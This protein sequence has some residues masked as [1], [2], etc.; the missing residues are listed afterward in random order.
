MEIEICKCTDLPQIYFDVQGVKKPIED[1]SP[2]QRCTALLPIILLETDTPLIIDQPEDNLDNQFI[3]DLVVNTLRSLKECRQII[4]AT[5]NPNIPVSGD[6][7]NIL[8][9]RPDG[10][11][12]KVERNGSIDY[13]PII[14]DVKTI[15][16]GGEEAFRVRARK[17]NL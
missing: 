8:V 9:F 13:G 3:F 16:E 7:E 2:G 11:K 5:H 17:Y 12:G 15:M 14:E 10:T 6:A 1:L 4:V